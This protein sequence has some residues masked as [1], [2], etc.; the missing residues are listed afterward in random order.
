[1]GFK[2]AFIGLMEGVLPFQKLITVWRSTNLK[3]SFH[4]WNGS[5]LLFT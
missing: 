2:T 5:L 4:L 3:N 1:M